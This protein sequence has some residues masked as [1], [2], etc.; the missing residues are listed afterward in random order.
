MN[1]NPFLD[2]N[3]KPDDG[4]LAERTEVRHALRE[5]REEVPDIDTEWERLSSR[6]HI[7]QEKRK[8]ILLR[9]RA[10]GWAAAAVVAITAIAAAVLLRL[11]MRT[12]DSGT[13]YVAK[14]D[15]GTSPDVVV[16][17]GNSL[18]RIKSGS[19][20]N[21]TGSVTAQ[22]DNEPDI[23]VI[24]ETTAGMELQV[25]LP[26]STMVWLWANSRLEFPEEFEGDFRTVKLTGE[27]YFDVTTDSIHPFVV[28]TPYFETRV[29]GT[30]FG[31]MANDRKTASILLVDGSLAVKSEP[32]TDENLL[33][34]GQMALLADDDTFVI[35][36]ADTYQMV[37]WR[38][39]LF[40]FDHDSL[41]D[42]LLRI[43]KWYNISVVAENQEALT[44]PMHFSADR[45]APIHEIVDILSE[46]SSAEVVIE[47]NT[48][49]VR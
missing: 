37:Q 13:I 46:L 30:E 19:V 17:R 5:A 38:D 47:D 24:I 34:P 21:A 3:G 42:V 48:I 49:I 11:D 10:A 1:R 28:E 7:R 44:T 6:L 16:K 20:Y 29:Y 12:H 8:F 41:F 9:G 23:P 26:D 39:G 2:D 18:Q 33:V 25:K 35:T 4:S 36:E 31:I 45:N 15:A 43:G 22:N 27:A 40:Y 14:T 32:E